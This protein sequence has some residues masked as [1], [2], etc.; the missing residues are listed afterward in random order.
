MRLYRA[1]TKYICFINQSLGNIII[2]APPL[3]NKPQKKY[4][5]IN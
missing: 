2:I 1:T 5:D 3:K 4:G